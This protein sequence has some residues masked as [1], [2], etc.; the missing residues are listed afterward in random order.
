M[1]NYFKVNGSFIFFE[2]TLRLSTERAYAAAVMAGGGC[3]SIWR[4]PPVHGPW[5]NV[6]LIGHR[7]RVSIINDIGEAHEALISPDM[8]PEFR[9]VWQIKLAQLLEELE[10]RNAAA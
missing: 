2:D 4:P 5:D 6:D 3:I 9:E 8:S 7:S 10:L 1:R